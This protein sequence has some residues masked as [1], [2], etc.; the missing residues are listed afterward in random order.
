MTV[1]VLSVLLIRAKCEL[2]C[3]AVEKIQYPIIDTVPNIHMHDCAITVRYRTLYI[4]YWLQVEFELIYI[5]IS[6]RAADC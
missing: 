3:S 5:C 4:T 2:I 6:L 1:L